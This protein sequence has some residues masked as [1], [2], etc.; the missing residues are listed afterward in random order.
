MYNV[1][2]ESKMYIIC[3]KTNYLS[4]VSAIDQDDAFVFN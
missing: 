3:I 4:A 2:A 1:N